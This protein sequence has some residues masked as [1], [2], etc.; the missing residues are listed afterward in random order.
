MAPLATV[1]IA[2][3]S[4]PTMFRRPSENPQAEASVALEW[5]HERVE[6]LKQVHDWRPDL[7]VVDEYVGY[8]TNFEFIRQI[9]AIDAQ[10]CTAA[11]SRLPR[12]TFRD[13]AA[14]CRRSGGRAPFGA[15]G[16]GT[17]AVKT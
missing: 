11:V 14:R 17:P 8:L 13:I 3:N 15:A 7:V 6:A 5:A 9:T 10:I 16:N 4:L 1:W 2:G 12:E